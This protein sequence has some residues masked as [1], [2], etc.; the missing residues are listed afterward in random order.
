MAQALGL[1][2]D[3]ADG[4][5]VTMVLGDNVFTDDLGA[6]IRSF[7]AP[8]AKV[9]LKEVPDPQRFGVPEMQAGKIVR[10]LEKPTAPPTN[11]CVTGLYCYDGSVFDLVR[12][13]KPSARGEYE[14]TDVN[15]AY[16]ERG[17]LS[18]EVIAGEWIDAG[19]FDSIL[20]ASQVI[21]ALRKRQKT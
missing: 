5:P 10:I 20:R 8:G 11:Y 9:F 17:Q 2:E 13:L 3:F 15:N 1:A 19:T 16:I 18:H 14:I 12:T 6:A 21:A 4:G 7:H